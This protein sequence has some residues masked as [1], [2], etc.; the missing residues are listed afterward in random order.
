MP[1]EQMLA[2]ETTRTFSSQRLTPRLYKVVRATTDQR[3]SHHLPLLGRWIEPANIEKHNAR[4]I[5][6]G[7]SDMQTAQDLT[8]RA[9]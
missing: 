6:Q 1:V 2:L 4:T 8:P 9:R 7:D 3:P 5:N